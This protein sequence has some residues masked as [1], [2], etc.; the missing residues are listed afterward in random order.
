[1]VGTQFERNEDVEHSSV[2]DGVAKIVDGI[3]ELTRKEG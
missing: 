2:L 1:M 3:I